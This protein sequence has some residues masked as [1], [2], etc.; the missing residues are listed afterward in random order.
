MQTSTSPSS[1]AA[2][3]VTLPGTDGKP[4]TIP[5]PATHSE[6]RQLV[7][8]QR[9]LGEQLN[10]ATERRTELVQQIITAPT[11]GSK[12]GLEARLKLLDQ[13]LLQ[14]ETDIATTNH[15][16]A[17]APAD[18]I[19]SAMYENRPQNSGDDFVEGVF[20]G[21]FGVFIPIVI[22]SLYMRRRRRK[23]KTAEPAN[24]LAADSTVRLERLERGMEAIAIEIERVSEGQRFVTKL[25]SESAH[26]VGARRL[27]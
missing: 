9:E 3:T 2:P 7:V 23:R 17:S 15:Q 14:L 19:E 16:I 26:P 27:E 21:G 18:L 5:L 11:E 6:I 4:V 1:P 20:A 10:A 22:I 25:L 24:A 8:R 12:A 13:Q